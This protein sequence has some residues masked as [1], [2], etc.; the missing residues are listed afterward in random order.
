VDVYPSVFQLSIIGLGVMCREVGFKQL[1]WAGRH[2]STLKPVKKSVSPAIKAHT[3]L[4]S[5][6]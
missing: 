5:A 4:I 3:A 2:L 1:I 6:P